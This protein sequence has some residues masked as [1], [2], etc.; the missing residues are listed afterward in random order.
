MFYLYDA[1]YKHKK[2]YLG[3]LKQ[4]LQC[5]CNKS[6][7]VLSGIV[8]SHP[9]SD[10]FCGLESLLASNL[11]EPTKLLVT[12]LFNPE[13]LLPHACAKLDSFSGSES[14]NV[15]SNKVVKNLF[16]RSLKIFYHYIDE[17]PKLYS[18]SCNEDEK[19]SSKLR[20]NESIEVDE[21]VRKK[22]SN[23][24]IEVDEVR[25]KSSKLKPN[26][27]SILL[28]ICEP[29]L[30]LLTGDELGGRI[31]DAI[32]GKP[33][34]V[35]QVPHHGSKRLPRSILQNRL[36]SESFMKNAALLWA[37]SYFHSD[38]CALIDKWNNV[39][40]SAKNFKKYFARK[41][42]E[43]CEE[44]VS[45]HFEKE[46]VKLFLQ[47][48]FCNQDQSGCYSLSN[49]HVLWYKQNK[50]KFRNCDFGKNL[51]KLVDKKC[52][53][54]LK[55]LH[56]LKDCIGWAY[57]YEQVEAG[58]FV[59]SGGAAYKGLP[60][61]EV[62]NGIMI[63]CK[64][65]QVKCR[66]A[67]TNNFFLESKSLSS[68]F[69]SVIRKYV[70]DDT[71]I[72]Y[73]NDFGCH[74]KWK[75]FFTVDINDSHDLKKEI[76]TIR[77]NTVHGMEP[78]NLN[79]IVDSMHDA[80]TSSASSSLSLLIA[81]GKQNASN[82][83]VDPPLEQFMKSIGYP[84]PHQ[85][86]EVSEV[87]DCLVGSSIT[88][89]LSSLRF[90]DSI[91][92]LKPLLNMKARNCSEFFMNNTKTGA[93]SA[94]VEV[95]VPK[96]SKIVCKKHEI[97]RAEF[98]VSHAKTSQMKLKLK[99][100]SRAGEDSC[101][102]LSRKLCLQGSCGE[103]LAEHVAKCDFDVQFW[104]TAK[105]VR[106]G[107][108]LHI[109]I[110]T[111]KSV[112]TTQEL[113]LFLMCR[114]VQWKVIHYLTT[115]YFNE[116][117]TL[118]EAHIHVRPSEEPIP[119]FGH[120]FLKVNSF[121]MH[122]LPPHFKCYK[123]I[124][125]EGNGIIDKVEV[126]FY[127]DAE[128]SKE[129]ELK[130]QLKE[131]LSVTSICDVLNLSRIS[132]QCMEPPIN[133]EELRLSE[134]I[135]CD[136]GFSVYQVL[137]G[138]REV[139]L[140]SLNFGV[141]FQELT[142]LLPKEWSHLN[143][144]SC[145]AAIVI[146]NPSDSPQL[147][148]KVAF[149]ATLT[150]DDQRSITL[151]S[152]LYVRSSH[153]FHLEVK[154]S[155]APY[156]HQ[157]IS[158]APLSVITSAL[159]GSSFEID[160]VSIPG[161][162]KQIL[163]NTMFKKLLL[164]LSGQE[165]KAFELETFMPRLDIIDSV[166][167]ITDSH[168]NL[169]FGCLQGLDLSCSGTI[170][171]QSNTVR[172]YTCD[173]KLEL[174]TAS[175]RGIV[176]FE[177]YGD[178][179]LGAFLESLGCLSKDVSSN[180]IL[181]S[182][183]SIAV[184]K[185]Q[186]E[187]GFC[188]SLHILNAEIELFMEELD[189]G[190]F[191]LNH[192]NLF[193]RIQNENE[194]SVSIMF[195]ASV[196]E[197]LSVELEYNSEDCSLTGT[198]SVSNIKGFES[199]GASTVLETLAAKP[200]ETSS[201][202]FESM[203]QLFQKKFMTVL[204]SPE[205]QQIEPGLT[206]YAHLR[207]VAS[208][209]R[210][211]S[212]YVDKF[213]LH[214]KDLLKIR[215]CSLDLIHVEYS[216]EPFSSPVVSSACLAAI[217][218]NISSNESMKVVFDLTKELEE[219]E[220]R[221]VTATVGPGLDNGLLKLRSVI[222]LAGSVCP[223]LP[224]VGL[225]PLFDLQLIHGCISF[226]IQPFS[227]CKLDVA[228]RMPEWLIFS[229]P[230]CSL[231]QLVLRAVWKKDTHPKLIFE[232]CSL[233]F[234][235]RKFDISGTISP[236]ELKLKCKSTYS[237][238]EAQSKLQ[239]HSLLKDYTPSS[240]PC[241]VVPENVCLP[242]ALD[243]RDIELDISLKESI[244][245]FGVKASIAPNCN[246][247]DFSF[248]NYTANVREIGG[249]LEWEKEASRSTYKAMLFGVLTLNTIEVSVKLLL[250]NSVG[251]VLTGKMF[252]M[253]YGEVAD[254]LTSQMQL[255]DGSSNFRQLVPERFQELAPIEVNMGLNVTKMQFFASGSIADL[256]ACSLLVGH[257]ENDDDMDYAVM[258]ALNEDFQFSKLSQSFGFIDEYVKIRSVQLL[259]SSVDLNQLKSVMKNFDS[260]VH[261]PF[262]SLSNETIKRGATLLAVLDVHSCKQSEGTLKALFEIGDDKLQE[263][264]IE[265]KAFICRDTKRDEYSQMEVYARISKMELFGMLEFSGIEVLYK[266]NRMEKP[267]YSLQLKGRV[268]FEC[269]TK[270]F[271]F[272]GRLLI[273]DSLAK[274]EASSCSDVLSNPGGMNI[275]VKDLKLSLSFE[276]YASK[277]APE[278]FIS[279]KVKIG[280]VEFT[281]SLLFKG[282]KFQVFHISLDRQLLLSCLFDHANI[283]WSAFSLKIGIKR[284]HFYY[285]REKAEYKDFCELCPE[286]CKSVQLIEFKQG[287]NLNCVICLFDWD[288]RIVAEIPKDRKNIKLSGR[289]VKKIDLCFAKLTGTDE[290]SDEGPEI[291]YSDNT[292]SLIAGVELFQQPY[293]K[294]RLSY[295]HTHKAFEGSITYLGTIL[296]MSNPTITVRWSKEKGFEIIEFP[297]SS[298][299]FNLLQAIAQFAKVLYNLI[300]G[301]VRWGIKLELRTDTNP[302]P[303]KYLAKLI[304]GGSITI[305]LFGFIENKL[306]PLPE[307]PLRIVKMNNFSLSRLP[308]FILSCLWESA[309]DICLSILRFLNP[310]ELAKQM[311][312]MIIDAVVGTV[313]TVA[314]LVVNV[315]KKAWGWCKSIF[316]FSA[317]LIDTDDSDNML[318]IGYV[319]AGKGGREL[320]CINHTVNRFGA[321]LISHAIGDIA[322]DVHEAAQ[323]CVN[324]GEK[325][326]NQEQ[327][328]NLKECTKK[329]SSNLT[330]AAE[331]ILTITGIKMTLDSTKLHLEWKAGDENGKLYNEDEGDIEY[332]VKIIAIT[333]SD[334]HKVSVKTLYSK[335][336]D[337]CSMKVMQV[338]EKDCKQRASGRKVAKPIRRSDKER[339]SFEQQGNREEKTPVDDSLPGVRKPSL[340]ID[341]DQKLIEKALCICATIHP[342][343]TLRIMTNPLHEAIAVTREVLDSE[344][345]QWFKETKEKI[346]E[347][348]RDK[349]VT[350]NGKKGHS[351]LIVKEIEL[352]QEVDITCQLKCQDNGIG[353]VICGVVSTM[354]QRRG[355]GISM[356][357]I[358]LVDKHDQTIILHKH[359]L[360]PITEKSEFSFSLNKKSIPENSNGPYT[361]TVLPLTA[362]FKGSRFLTVTDFEIPRS[363]HVGDV[364]VSLLEQG[365][366]AESSETKME[367][368]FSSNKESD[369]QYF[370][371]ISVCGF[372]TE[373]RLKFEKDTAL[374]K[375]IKPIFEHSTVIYPSL[376]L[377]GEEETQFSHSF[378]L[379]SLYN[380]FN[381]SLTSGAVVH[382][383]VSTSS[384]NGN[385]FPSLTQTKKFII[386]ASPSKF[387]FIIVEPGLKE[388]AG[389]KLIWNYCGNAVKYQLNVLDNVT[390]EIKWSKSFNYDIES[391]VHDKKSGTIECFSNI[392]YNDFKD[393]SVKVQNG[394][395]LQMHSSGF[396]D[397]IMQSLAP[398]I[399]E[400]KL[401][402]VCATISY[403]SYNDRIKCLFSS[404]KPSSSIKVALCQRSSSN[405]D[406]VLIKTL[407]A[408]EGVGYISFNSCFW[409]PHLKNGST[410]CLWLYS[411]N[412]CNS[413]SL[414]MGISRNEIAVLESPD[415]VMSTP[416]YN[417]D[418]T[419]VG[420]SLC[421]S[422]QGCH[423]Q[424]G[425]TS[426]DT[427]GII[428][429][430]DSDASSASICFSDI[431]SP[432][433]SCL[434]FQ[435]FV[436]CSSTNEYVVASNPSLDTT[437]YQCITSEDTGTFVFTG[438]SLQRA[439]TWKT[440]S[441]FASSY[442]HPVELFYRAVPS[443]EPFP[444]YLLPSRIIRKFWRE[445]FDSGKLHYN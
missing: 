56:F 91:G 41:N 387:E 378:S 202:T 277:S 316:G 147:G 215:N 257:L 380:Q 93:I 22:S 99:L 366:A 398:K 173:T 400:Q 187:F 376:E 365:D 304:I 10:H 362:Y 100:K 58:L 119:L 227:V 377:G 299:P 107:E 333:V 292:L 319:Y 437:L 123:A 367:W 105:E 313:K 229:D 421:W 416:Q 302:D 204:K 290:Y 359:L 361:I 311:G 158:D 45:N 112:L 335:T 117:S 401:T 85:P 54:Y 270:I 186:I 219:D 21:E 77:M 71:E 18:L 230:K 6:K 372:P 393:L 190:I 342:T 272:D 17:S 390:K 12:S 195:T 428:W 148:L 259:I 224:D 26:E 155:F 220:G 178:L 104:M 267:R 182:A 70:S 331:T 28:Q 273:S 208:S 238:F 419:V 200:A 439:L 244:K 341:I 404:F 30:A 210:K 328:N 337:I 239:F 126:Q 38:L 296:W 201:T 205:N 84:N 159:T 66:I 128:S 403:E 183:L 196:A 235:E 194:R 150:I 113:P 72:W 170:N 98:V 228:V 422:S 226:N 356:Y 184:R 109:L 350:L 264:R 168:L 332:H 110:G 33:L 369:Q 374:L 262:S 236:K 206:A 300:T 59:I 414:S 268:S 383:K 397:D 44:Q 407:C 368:N 96:K 231:Q 375:D 146:T 207:L 160:L 20:P 394:V 130:I 101:V 191:N 216:S 118:K 442:L 137:T 167:F 193:V 14:Y 153:E 329:L 418:W 24:S 349:E 48:R 339:K 16:H 384:N 432:N 124:Q 39:S 27:S 127:S 69:P 443:G 249:A 281:A 78:L 149:T 87:L 90:D 308:E 408:S 315:A 336:I 347:N 346:K 275:T 132:L 382:C 330:I 360:H 271:S 405:D 213:E 413:N 427:G 282:A 251:T 23:E 309:G 95:Y 436:K 221:V 363:P 279:G 289:S 165:V 381:L 420:T 144:S 89:Q 214:L 15:R 250:G 284:G 106:L 340:L 43:N 303:S 86:H 364:S 233:F 1:G 11:L 129:N 68:V 75:P 97:E 399:S 32:G 242:A 280:S 161:L 209:K 334:S 252:N 253:K 179:T 49:P 140:K 426:S 203:K 283:D 391:S 286:C 234:L 42:V 409:R 294:G 25:K 176:C 287:F 385:E 116:D 175:K 174:S 53:Q 139:V 355:K 29:P 83:A 151:D 172:H 261:D 82:R 111:E 370:F 338:N 156:D 263:S 142:D 373:E 326:I 108:I 197:S 324:A 222:D 122:I 240:E 57:F 88:S 76:P 40:Q 9:H 254:M 344:D 325:E 412:N 406:P 354:L 63:A 5:L 50:G 65:R 285:A 163:R 441:N 225:P 245:F 266:L 31:I 353:Y 310:I 2:K 138:S 60:T 188:T 305:T 434:H 135:A 198:L 345:K 352:K 154:P 166:L 79:S 248:G 121:V 323:T 392:G 3:H 237:D 8:I 164:H 34:G 307:I 314:K 358:Q 402:V 395:K 192:I 288:F 379:R 258:I 61:A 80:L 295:I 430:M 291:A 218:R 157:E 92:S 125:I 143:I 51:L 211:R 255:S 371:N 246:S 312:K 322:V 4:A 298:T 444:L 297:L 13:N 417:S 343:V 293:F 411:D 103:T 162:G 276:T 423:Y 67:L 115:V 46:L 102:D 47:Q 318:L 94:K 351:E 217:L 199:V 177:N 152:L 429:S 433:F 37:L 425:I 348:G 36:P 81:K 440:A 327:L 388:K 35:F 389:L 169:R 19:K 189:I 145:K 357:L 317:F 445:E 64:W 438:V 171:L 181:S 269:E 274:F 52:L 212:F 278:I 386:V 62:L 435:L 301:I 265:I 134:A 424:Y 410:F 180:T 136:A 131:S 306:I 120:V 260:N 223:D 74:K 133:K 243:I 431:V 241:P 55:D 256:G 141:E 247:W 320:R 415:Y 396:G 73:L 321:F 7:F 114:A 185:V 232:N